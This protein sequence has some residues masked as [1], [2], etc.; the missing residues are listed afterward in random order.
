MDP[1]RVIV[2]KL[3]YC[4]DIRASY[5]ISKLLANAVTHGTCALIHFFLGSFYSLSALYLLRTLH[6]P[7]DPGEDILV[8]QNAACQ[9]LQFFYLRSKLYL[10][11]GILES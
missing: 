3:E 10:S 2:M 9:L 5:I 7:G 11:G 1:K 4:P 6:D 8:H